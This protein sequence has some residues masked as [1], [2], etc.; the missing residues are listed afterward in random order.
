[1]YNRA[2]RQRSIHLLSPSPQEQRAG[3]DDRQI[4]ICITG[5]RVG[6]LGR[7]VRDLV[8]G[9]AGHWHRDIYCPYGH[10]PFRLGLSTPA[11]DERGGDEPESL[12]RLRDFK[13][14][15]GV[16][17]SAPTPRERISL[18]SSFR[19]RVLASCASS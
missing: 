8:G 17:Q 6:H 15:S 3:R 10:P 19:S 18:A 14:A 2:G 12:H 5:E 13:I 9:E 7:L 4:G 11:Q 16:R 1:P